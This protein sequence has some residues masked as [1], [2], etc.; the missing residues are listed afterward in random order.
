M[1][2]ISALSYICQICK[3]TVTHA[4]GPHYLDDGTL[5]FCPEYSG[6]TVVHLLASQEVP[7]SDEAP[8][9]IGEWA[10]SMNRGVAV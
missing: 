2:E 7:E 8:V 1:T 6:A 3:K 10:E 5:L 9:M 4:T